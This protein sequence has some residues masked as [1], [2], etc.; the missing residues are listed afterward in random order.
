V[1]SGSTPQGI[2]SGHTSDQSF[3]RGDGRAARRRA[4]GELGPVLAEAPPLPPQNGV[5][6][7][8]HERLPPPGPNLGQPDPEEAIRRAKLGPGQP[9]LVY[10]KLL[11]KSEVFKGELLMAAA[12]EGEETQQVEQEGDH[13]G[14]S[15][16]ESG[17]QINQLAP[18]LGFGEGQADTSLVLAENAVE[19][20]QC[21][22]DYSPSQSHHR[23]PSSVARRITVTFS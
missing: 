2:G 15:L 23:L 11:S 12:E 13:R 20:E 8:D 4:P 17:R 10:G 21:P 1:N 9:P 18:G 16:F 22:R 6:S 3:D 5:G 7:N 19:A 14:G